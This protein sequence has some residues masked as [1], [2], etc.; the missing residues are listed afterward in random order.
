MYVTNRVAEIQHLTEALNLKHIL[1][2]D[3]P[4]DISSKR[5]DPTELQGCQVWWQGPAWLSESETSW[6]SIITTG[7]MDVPE[8]WMTDV[9]LNA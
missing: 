9:S 1:S 6:P 4:A 2:E 8:Q 5:T 3:N 7:V